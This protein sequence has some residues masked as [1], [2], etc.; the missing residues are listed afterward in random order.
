MRWTG[1]GLDPR[2]LRHRHA[3]SAAA[4]SAQRPSEAS[5]RAS[6]E[7]ASLEVPPRWPVAEEHGAAQRTE[8]GQT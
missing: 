7:A 3:G 1:A 6:A 2:H 5:A 4:W 8:R